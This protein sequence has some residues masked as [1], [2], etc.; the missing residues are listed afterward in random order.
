MQNIHGARTPSLRCKNLSVLGFQGY[1]PRLSPFLPS[2]LTL[3]FLRMTE[4]HD[5]ALL[6]LLH[7]QALE[8]LREMAQWHDFGHAEMSLTILGRMAGI[9]ELRLG[10]L[11]PS[12]VGEIVNA[13]R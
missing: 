8:P 7:D 9:D 11:D 12:M 10:R 5:P 4:S 1:P 2:L 6:K 13:V 3:L